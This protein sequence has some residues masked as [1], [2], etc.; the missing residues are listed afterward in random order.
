MQT[1]PT[2]IHFKVDTMIFKMVVVLENPALPIDCH[3][4]SDPRS[5]QL[6]CQSPVRPPTFLI[7]TI[8]SNLI[9]P[10]NTCTNPLSFLQHLIVPLSFYLS[11]LQHP[12]YTLCKHPPGR[13][14]VRADLSHLYRATSNSRCHIFRMIT[15]L[16]LPLN[17]VLPSKS[18]I[19]LFQDVGIVVIQLALRAK[20]L[21][22]GQM[23]LITTSPVQRD[24]GL[25]LMPATCLLRSSEAL[26]SI[27]HRY[28]LPRPPAPF[29]LVDYPNYHLVRLTP[30]P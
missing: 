27:N 9:Q 6:N 7:S 28:L 22:F 17:K 8:Q 5:Y 2:S 12:M 30:K 24:C 1:F 16:I 11:P 26:K 18:I 13:Q 21:K 4:L 20:A 19:C 29:S 10:L 14:H 25:R 15:I 3:Q 23:K